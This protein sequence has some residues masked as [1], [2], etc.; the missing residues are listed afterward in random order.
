MPRE[1]LVFNNPSDE[2][3]I[4]DKIGVVGGTKSELHDV[5]KCLNVLK[6]IF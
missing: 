6:T 4:E 5:Q 3:D 2:A 1:Y